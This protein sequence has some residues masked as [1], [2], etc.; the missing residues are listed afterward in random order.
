MTTSGASIGTDAGNEDE[1]KDKL[2]TIMRIMLMHQQ[3][4]VEEDAQVTDG[5]SWFDEDGTN[6]EAHVE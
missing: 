1:K 3:F 4:T 6:V 2:M 5:V